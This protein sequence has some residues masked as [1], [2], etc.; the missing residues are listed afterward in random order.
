MLWNNKMK[1]TKIDKSHYLHIA[2]RALLPVSMFLLVKSDFINIA[3]IMV[4]LSKWRIFSVKARHWAANISANA[5]DIIFSLASIGAYR[6]FASNN[7][8]LILLLVGAL[9]WNMYIKPKSSPAYV[10]LQGVIAFMASITVVYLSYAQLPSTSLG[11]ASAVIG[12]FCMHHILGSF[13]DSMR[14][15]VSYMWCILCFMIS[16]IMSKWLIFYGYIAQ[17]ALLLAFL[18]L[19]FS[20]YNYIYNQPTKYQKYKKYPLVTMVIFCVITIFNSNLRLSGI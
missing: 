3:V 1:W 19:G 10:S 7:Q 4:L 16:V 12:Y 8:A 15:T 13:G 5:V 11:L 20:T 14:V 9:Y 2:F 17:P 6:A 18:L